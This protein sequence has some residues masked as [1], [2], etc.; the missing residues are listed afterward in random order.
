MEKT[1]K[2]KSKFKSRLYR[3]LII[4]LLL[5]AI[6]IAYLELVVNPIIINIAEAKVDSVA[7]TAISDAIFKVVTDNDVEYD[8]LVEIIYDSTGNIASIVSNTYKMNYFARELS[9]HAQIL[10][11]KIAATGIDIPIGAFT[12]M[13]AFSDVGPNC[14]LKLSPIGSVITAFN[15]KFTSAGINQ[16]LHSLY[17]DVNTSISVVLPTRSRKIEFI[18]Q[19]LVCETIIVGK[20][21]D[22]YLNGSIAS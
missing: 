9:T 7:T 16:T 13:P 10:L 22:V 17:V 4:L 6:V 21:P 5:I 2:K 11:D 1:C 3:S 15:S 18:T 12:G 8:D 14:N 19:A 20:I